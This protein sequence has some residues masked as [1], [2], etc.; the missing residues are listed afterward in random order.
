[1]KPIVIVGAGIGG[2]TAGA[3]LARSGCP[4]VV[5]EAHTDV[6]GCAATFEREGFRFDVGATLAAGFEPGMPLACLGEVLGIEW[7]ARLEPAAMA[8]HLPDGTSVVRWADRDRWREERRDRF[9]PTAERFWRWQEEAAQAFWAM[10]RRR[11]PWPPQTVREGLDLVRLGAGWLGEDP[12]RVRWLPDLFRKVADHLPP[13]LPRLRAFVDAQLLISAQARSDSVWAAYGA[14]ALDLP[15]MGVGAVPGGIGGVAERL[16]DALR[17][18]GGELHRCQEVVRVRRVRSGG[19]RVE[20]HTGLVI[21]AE[22][23]IFNL[24]PADVARILGEE[25]PASLRNLPPAPPDGWGAFALYLGIRGDG[26]ALEGPLHHQIVSGAGWGEG[27]T[28]FLSLSPAWDPSRAPLGHR[29]VTI[30][31]HTALESW[32]A[33]WEKDREAYAERKARMAEQL[34][35]LATWVIPDLKARILRMEVGTPI[36]FHRFTRRS[37]GWVGGFPQTRMGRGWGARFGPGLWLVGD[38]VFPGQS[39]PAVV[40]GAWRT[41]EALLKALAET[42]TAR[43][44]QIPDV[45]ERRGPAG[46]DGPGGRGLNLSPSEEGAQ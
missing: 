28:V 10:A 32:W 31:T 6:G 36:T 23:V 9:G 24:T 14:A 3:L 17:R 26:L 21:E 20:A 12:G 40:L 18:H 22:Q 45:P 11:P 29:A 44:F 2:L 43:R 19:F 16:A 25:A 30:T 5:L 41:A 37:R 39:I 35:E 46:R 15:H 42:R 27:R 33:L 1:M 4:V 13:D 8:V 38:S 7:E 34:L